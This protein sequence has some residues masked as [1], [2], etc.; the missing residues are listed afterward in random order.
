[1]WNTHSLM[2]TGPCTQQNFNKKIQHKPRSRII[3]FLRQWKWWKWETH[4]HHFVLDKHSLLPGG[5][6]T[7]NQEPQSGEF[8]R[9]SYSSSTRHLGQQPTIVWISFLFVRINNPSGWALKA[10]GGFWKHQKFWLTPHCRWR[11][12]ASVVNDADVRGSGCLPLLNWASTQLRWIWTMAFSMAIAT[13][14]STDESKKLETPASGGKRTRWI[15]DP[16]MPRLSR[17]STVV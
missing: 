17:V 4:Q 6:L 9:S 1:M 15:R 12:S 10:S 11:G 16:R 7:S 8:S 13:A 14:F 5:K 3:F 2:T